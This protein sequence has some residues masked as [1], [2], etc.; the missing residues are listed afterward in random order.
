MEEVATTNSPPSV[1][2][3]TMEEDDERVRYELLDFR[4]RQDFSVSRPFLELDGRASLLHSIRHWCGHNVAGGGDWISPIRERAFSGIF[5]RWV[6][7]ALCSWDI[8]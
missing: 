5:W 7:G 4:H 8:R 2:H 3:Q 1:V 6:D